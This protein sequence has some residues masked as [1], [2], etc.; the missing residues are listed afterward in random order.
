VPDPGN[1]FWL[2]QQQTIARVIRN[3]PEP[4]DGW[5]LEWIRYT[6]QG[7]PWRY[8]I[9]SAVALVV[10]LSVYRR[11]THLSGAGGPS[12]SRQLAQLDANVLVALADVAA[13]VTPWAD[14]LN[15]GPH[16]EE[17]GTAALATGDLV[18]PQPLA[19]L[20]DETDLSGAELERLND[21]LGGG[22]TS[23]EG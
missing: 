11:A 20:Q 3:L 16:D 18:G 15:Y 5:S 1:A 10:A 4:R 21:L 17:V 14:D 12:I 9:A 22:L 6:L 2:Q 7:S 8:P 13:A 23:N 19:P